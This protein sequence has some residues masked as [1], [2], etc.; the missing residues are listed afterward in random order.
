MT[1]RRGLTLLVVVGGFIGTAMAAAPRPSGPTP[2]LVTVQVGL[3][4]L[5]YDPGPI[6]GWGGPR[7]MAALTAY[8][9]DRRIVLNQ[10][11]LRLVLELLQLDTREEL[12]HAAGPDRPEAACEPRLLPLQQW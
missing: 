1:I 3:Y 5:G 4:M 11:T 12:R 2:A 7:T 10:A 6:D 9:E 8:A